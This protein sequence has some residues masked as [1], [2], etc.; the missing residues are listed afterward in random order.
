MSDMVMRQYPRL[1]E[2]Y[3][4]SFSYN[5]LQNV[6]LFVL[7]E[8]S[9]L[10]FRKAKPKY[11][12]RRD[13]CYDSKIELPEIEKICY[14]SLD[15]FRECGQNEDTELAAW[16]SFFSSTEPAVIV[17]LVNRHPEF[18]EM[19]RGIAEFRKRPEVFM[20]MFSEA[21]Y[22]MDR[23]AE[24]MMVEDLQ[25]ENEDLQ[26]DMEELSKKYEALRKENE[27]LKQQLPGQ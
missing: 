17:S 21:L 12:H 19:Y 8:N 20:K 14:I 5:M 7:M 13:S 22:I 25:K 11:I 6:Y 18:L 24:R 23:N 26:K 10:V 27:A 1:K 16:L 2:N 9:P 3:K 4:K 15:S